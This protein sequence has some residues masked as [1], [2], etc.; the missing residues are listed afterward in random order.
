MKY[1]ILTLPFILFVLL[2]VEISEAQEIKPNGYNQFTYPDGSISSEGYMKNGKPE[3]FWKSYYPDGTL[4]SEGSRKNEQLDSIWK[5]YDR[6]GHLT[7]IIDYKSGVKSGYHK[8]YKFISDSSHT[9]NV[10]ISKELYVNNEKN[11][12]SYYY[13]NRGRLQKTIE[14]EKN[15]KNGYEKQFDTTGLVTYIIKYSFNNIIDSEKINRYDNKG[16]KQGIWKIFY[17]NEKLNIY[18]NYLN[19]TLN[20]YYREYNT[21][22][23]LTKT[24]F[25][26]MGKL[27]TPE[28]YENEQEKII[29]K[30]EYHPNGQIKFSGSYIDTIPV[31]LHRIFDDKGQIMNSEIFSE[32]GKLSGEGITDKESKKQ[33]H[34][35]FYYD[36]G[37]LK[38]ESN[39][40]NDKRNGKWLYYYNSG[41]TEQTGFYNA[42][43]PEGIWK[44]YYENGKLRRTGEFKNGLEIGFYYELTEEGDTL[45]RGNYSFG[46]KTGEWIYHVNDYKETGN[47]VSGKKEGIWRHYYDDGTLQYEGNYTEGFPD[48]KH[49]TFYPDG[50]VKLIAYYSAGNKE[51]KWKEYDSDGNLTVLTEYKGGKKFKINGQIL[52]SK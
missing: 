1:K 5:F 37:K 44:W 2:F 32:T 8:K 40:I 50:K 16:R 36:D 45:S 9:N 30:K 11:G 39:F 17:P 18:A 25:Y 35:K 19:D 47:Y 33:G 27:K 4:K 38:S 51:N 46:F 41:I 34:W 7:E 13:E 49:K 42:G 43:K 21:Y 6:A 52:K 28:I 23:E 31:G 3:G 24:E 26:V 12:K 15:Y 48:G 20:G 14:F 22:G 10:L 29:I